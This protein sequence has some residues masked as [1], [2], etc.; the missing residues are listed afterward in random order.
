MELSFGQKVDESNGVIMPWFTHPSLDEISKMD[1]SNKIVWMFGAGLGD[2]WLAK[3]CRK[4]YIVERSLDWLE[5][6]SQSAASN[7]IENI[8]YIHRPCNDSSGMQD[9]Y[10]EI[11]ESVDVIINDDAYRFEVIEKALT[12]PRPLI[13]ITDNWMQSYVFLCP[14]GVELLKGFEAHIH[15]QA[16]HL[17]ND[18]INKWKTAI[19]FLK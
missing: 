12:L 4:I 15:E 11:I 6:A 1:L 14:A 3:R 7:G 9:Y 18:G 5:R 17:D 16:D 19:H 13:L 2:S 8:T 10:T